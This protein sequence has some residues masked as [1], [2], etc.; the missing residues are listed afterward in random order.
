MPSGAL[1][2]NPSSGSRSPAAAEGIRRRAQ[3][4]GIDLVEVEESLDIAED[5][6]GRIA[7]GQRLFI[8]AGG[9]GTIHT[10]VQALVSTEAVLGILP[11]GTFNHFA[12]DLQI[13]LD[14]EAAFD[15]AVRGKT[16]QVSAG[17]VND[18]YFLNN[19]SIGLY[20]EVAEQREELRHHSKWRAYVKA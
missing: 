19:M 7:A 8:A 4:E 13:P 16:I 14:W 20:P 3:E 12:R 6:R 17:A 2:F 15:I 10:V 11:V 18:H 5:I 1:Y 9:D